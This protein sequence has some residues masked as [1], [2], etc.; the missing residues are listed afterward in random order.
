M[1]QTFVLLKPD[2]VQR[3]LLGQITSRLEQKGL[4]L[5]GMKMLQLDDAILDEHY[6]HLKDKPF[7][8]GT[9]SFMKSAPVVACVWHGKEAVDVVRAL[10]GATN[11]RKAAPGTIRGDLGISIQANLIHASDSIDTAKAEVKRFFKKD[12]LFHYQKVMDPF[13]YS[14]DEKS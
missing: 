1:E 11:S 6:A 7:F 10:C 14:K 13:L 8:A 5:V 9:K 2:A 3:G 12:E 4:Q